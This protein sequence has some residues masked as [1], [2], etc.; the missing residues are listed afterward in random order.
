M[1]TTELL[2][3]TKL[4]VRFYDGLLTSGELQSHL[5]DFPKEIWDSLPGEKDDDRCLKNQVLKLREMIEKGE[6]FVLKDTCE[7]KDL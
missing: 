6:S 4:L 7:V 3:V 5:V 2:E 1:E